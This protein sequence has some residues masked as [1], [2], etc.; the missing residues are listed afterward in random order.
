MDKKPLRVINRTGRALSV[1][2]VIWRGGDAVIEVRDGMPRP[3]IDSLTHVCAQL[4]L[5][6]CEL[7]R[8]LSDTAPATALHERLLETRRACEDVGQWLIGLIADSQ[9]DY[10]EMS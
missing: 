7:E 6:R 2:G 10:E 8:R 1:S 4:E 5:L 3:S 9:A